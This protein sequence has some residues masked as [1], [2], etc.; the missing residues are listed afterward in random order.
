MPV[1]FPGY[2]QI[3]KSSSL[4]QVGN[5]FPELGVLAD[6]INSFSE[7]SLG[8]LIR[9]ANKLRATGYIA[10]ISGSDIGLYKISEVD[11]LYPLRC[12]PN[13]MVTQSTRDWSFQ[14]SSINLTFIFSGDLL[15]YRFVRAF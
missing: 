1:P 3:P 12:A 9:W 5:V 7:T 4:V 2:T 8:A 10:H 6:G 14:H 15:I 11:I 13:V